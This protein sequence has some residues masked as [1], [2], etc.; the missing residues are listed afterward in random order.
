MAWTSCSRGPA[1]R[2]ARRPSG[3]RSPTRS[4]PICSCR[5][6]PTTPAGSQPTARRPSST[7]RETHPATN[8]VANPATDP[9]RDPVPRP[10]PA[11]A[12]RSS[13][14]VSRTC[15]CA[16]SWH[17]AASPTAELTLG[18]GPCCA[19]PGCRRSGSTS[20]TSAILRCGGAVQLAH[21][22]PYRRGRRRRA[23]TPLPGRSGH[24]PYGHAQTCR[25][26]PTPRV[27]RCG[28]G[29]SAARAVTQRLVTDAGAR[30]SVRRC[31]RHRMD[32]GHLGERLAHRRGRSIA[33]RHD[34]AQ[35]EA[36][37]GRP[38]GPS[39]PGSRGS[40]R[41]CSRGRRDACPPPGG[42]PR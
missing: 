36:Q 28:A 40:R 2:A 42:E 10:G 23:A 14:S 20:A 18:A 15:S 32:A 21:A 39:P 3:L 5:S 7:D 16:R 25:P 29:A 37:A 34:R 24:R 30:D 22:R 38:G 19:G 6:T 35:V 1:G 11:A 31:L 8:R 27:H 17:E 9:A 4:T 12:G 26:A 33:D 13:A 41:R